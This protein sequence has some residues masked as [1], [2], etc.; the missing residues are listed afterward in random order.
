MET[1]IRIEGKR[2]NTFVY[3]LRS[4]ENYTYLLNK[5]ITGSTYYLKC[6][7]KWCSFSGQFKKSPEGVGIGE[8]D[9]TYNVKNDH[10]HG[11]NSSAVANL[12]LT[13]AAKRRARNSSDRLRDI[14]DEECIK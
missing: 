7:E 13:E 5:T 6:S 12:K 9:G 1:L 11:P 8:L 10:N 4:D 14:F 2:K 3:F